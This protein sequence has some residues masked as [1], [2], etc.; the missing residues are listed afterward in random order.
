MRSLAPVLVGLAALALVPAAP[1]QNRAGAALDRLSQASSEPV[2]VYR[3]PTTRSPYFVTARIPVSGF[4]RS[5]SAARR[6]ADFW[7]AYGGLFGVTDAA[8]ELDLRKATTDTYGVTHLRYDQRYRGLEVVGRQLLLHL[9]DGAVIAANGHFADGIEL[10]TTPTV[11]ETGAAFVASGGILVRGARSPVGSATL[12]VHVNGLDH[13][14]LAWRVTVASSEPLGIWRVF[15]DARTAEVLR[16]YNDLHTARDRR[17]H[18]NGNDPDCNMTEAP[19]CTLPG[20]QVRDEDD[21]PVGDAIVQETHVNTGL[22]Y[23]YFANTFGRDSYDEAGHV[24]RS[25]VH[26]GAGFDNAFWCGDDCAP[27]FGSLLGGQMVY[28]DGSWNGTSGLFSPLG[29]DLDVVAHELTHA[30]TEHENGLEYSG[31]SGAL[32]ESYS[33]VFAAMVDQDGD[34]W[35]LSEDSWTPGTPGDALRNM[36]DPADEGQPAHMNDYVNTLYDNGGV[37]TNSGIPNHAA[38]LAATDPG[39]G[40]G[41]AD[42]QHIY[43]AAMPCLS[44]GADFLENLQCLLLAA[45][46]VFPGDDAKARAIRLSQAAVGIAGR[47]TVSSPNGGETFAPGGAASV[48]WSGGS[49]TGTG[50][51]VSFFQS[52]PENHSEGFESGPSLPTDFTTGSPPWTVVGPSSGNASNSARSGVIAD[53]GRTELHRVVHVR[54]SGS[55]FFARRVS[56]EFNFDFLS[57]HVDGIPV[58]ATSGNAAWGF[59]VYV[60]ITLPPGAH[61]L[62][63]VYEK[64]SIVSVGEDA[65]W[66]DVVLVPNLERAAPSAINASTSA[67]ATSQPWTVPNA[68]GGN[69]RIRVQR[70]GIAPWLAFD[71]S[72]GVFAIQAPP[73][74]PTPPPPA[75]Q[76]Q[77]RPPAQARCVVPNVR[78]RTV[79]RARRLLASRRCRLGRVTR[80]YSARMRRGTILRQSRRPGARLRRGTRVNVVVSR[81]RRR[82]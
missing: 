78:G 54:S 82:R 81:G 77:P 8:E 38:Y 48:T 46:V 64:D 13:A 35:L 4:S 41:R 72:D 50:F 71:E 55:L 56:S 19:D 14:R 69:Y 44:V 24:L 32:N 11:S 2:A 47:P 25:T 27:F 29:Q 36:A 33:D 1:A 15:V 37:H 52:A 49:T 21:P 12:L 51:G 9:R 43:Y 7:R 16:A 61:E 70:L 67:D 63:W 30:I 5:S 62:V 28:G 76:P 22:V 39:Y 66:I 73:P 10:G 57:F 59:P 68:P 75:P 34:E 17:T 60:P 18:T 74:P 20:V 26:F 53:N 31:Q 42:L 58:G 79:A 40:I 65:A 3:N 80:A 45:G 6:G 23:D